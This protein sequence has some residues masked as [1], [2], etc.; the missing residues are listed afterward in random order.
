MFIL[1]FTVILIILLLIS[2]I[3]RMKE[4]QHIMNNLEKDI[5]NNFLDVINLEN[6]V[7]TIEKY[8][9]CL[10]YENYDYDNTE[11]RLYEYINPKESEEE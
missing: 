11:T 8:L 2:L 1:I 3:F 5:G 7:N 4:L 9:D 6:R 10:K